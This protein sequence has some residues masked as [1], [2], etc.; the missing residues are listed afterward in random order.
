MCLVMGI[1]YAGKDNPAWQ[2]AHLAIIKLLQSSWDNFFGKPDRLLTVIRKT[3]ITVYITG[4]DPD[5][6]P[7]RRSHIHGVLA[8]HLAVKGDQ[9][10]GCNGCPLH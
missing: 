9:A 2:E 5:F 10:K 1:K 4:S 8:T 6:K 3:Q 7:T